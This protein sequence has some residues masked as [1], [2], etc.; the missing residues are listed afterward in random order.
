MDKW[1][2][3]RGPGT[4]VLM[5]GGILQVPFEQLDEF[6]VECV[7][8]VRLIRNSLFIYFLTILKC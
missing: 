3:D 2:T 7:H 6:Y 5:D 4:H 8:A 1:A